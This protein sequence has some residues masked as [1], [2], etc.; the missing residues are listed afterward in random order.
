[1]PV[2]FTIGTVFELHRLP[3]KIRPAKLSQ[4]AIEMCRLRVAPVSRTVTAREFVRAII[5]ETAFCHR[6]LMNSGDL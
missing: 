3:R 6:A 2:L 1:M 4:A 5:D